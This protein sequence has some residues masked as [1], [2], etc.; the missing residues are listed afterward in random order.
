MAREY[1]KSK[2][3][4]G[5]DGAS[6]LEEF[7][8]QWNELQRRNAENGRFISTELSALA[9]IEFTPAS[10]EDS[11][12]RIRAIERRIFFDVDQQR[13]RARIFPQAALVSHRAPRESATRLLL[14]CNHERLRHHA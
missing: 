2:E 5:L 6:G 11:L 3:I 12:K 8:Q 9:R 7:V 14:R 1:L 4:I 10:V 13:V